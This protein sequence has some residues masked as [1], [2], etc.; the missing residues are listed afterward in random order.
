M[1]LSAGRPG[2]GGGPG[3]QN[4]HGAKPNCVIFVQIYVGCA[5]SKENKGLARRP[6][7]FQQW[8]LEWGCAVSNDD[9]E[10]QMMVSQGG[11]RS[12]NRGDS[13]GVNM[14]TDK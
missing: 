8:E 1:N 4:S 14:Y 2:G 13:R 10:Q 12:S 3:V 7:E 5:V 9:H 6:Q 11:R